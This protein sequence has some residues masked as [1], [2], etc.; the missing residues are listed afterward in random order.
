M[1]CGLVLVSAYVGLHL[2]GE[3]GTGP[4][5]LDAPGMTQEAGFKNRIRAVNIRSLRSNLSDLEVQ[6]LIGESDLVRAGL[7][8]RGVADVGQLLQDRL[9]EI[10]PEDGA[11]RA[12]Y[13]AHRAHFGRRSFE[14]SRYALEQLVRIQIIKRELGISSSLD[15]R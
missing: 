4:S 2:R 15:E 3:R 5:R 12:Y 6:H 13:E 9:G 1:V 7:E 11:L 10:Q 8:A 14:Q